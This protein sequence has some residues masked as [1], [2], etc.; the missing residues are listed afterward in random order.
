MGYYMDLETGVFASRLIGQ[1]HSSYTRISTCRFDSQIWVLHRDRFHFESE[2]VDLQK[3]GKTEARQTQYIEDLENFQG[4]YIVNKHLICLQAGRLDATDLSSGVTVDSVPFSQER[5]TMFQP[6]HG[7][8]S[9]LLSEAPDRSNSNSVCEQALFTFDGMK[10]RKIANWRSLEDCVHIWSASTSYLASLHVDGK[11]TEIRDSKSGEVIAE[12]MDEPSL[13]R[14]GMPIDQTIVWETDKGCTD[15][16]SG[17]TLPVPAGSR[18]VA[19]DVDGQQL[20]TLRKKTNAQLGWDC[21]V[22]DE[23]NGKELNRF[24]IPLKHCDS[25]SK[26]EAPAFWIKSDRLVIATR[27]YGISIYDLK[28]GELIREFDPFIWSERWSWIAAFGFGIWCIVWLNGSAKLHPHGWLDMAVCS[29]LVIACCCI[30]NQYRS[31]TQFELCICFGIFGCW[32]LAATTWLFFGKTRWSLRFQP[33][34][35]LLGATFGIVAGL[36]VDIT[37]LRS[38]PVDFAFGE[39]FLMAIYFFSMIL[40]RCSGL[41]F[42]VAEESAH[43]TK[44]KSS[45]LALRDLFTL[46]IVFALLFTIARW[47]PAVQWLKAT[48]SDW[49]SL[50]MFASMIALPSLLAMWTATSCRGWSIRWGVWLVAAIAYEILAANVAW[51]VFRRELVLSSATATLFCFYAYRLRGWRLNPPIDPKRQQCERPSF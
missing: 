44:P 25:D 15:I 22:L 37:W 17:K 8:Q 11:T 10:I 18:L 20:V 41:R 39:M 14:K 21:I 47:M 42:V 16:L 4:A 31:E 34:L 3:N 38:E 1:R 13:I 49:K 2:W 40:L 12:Y 7:T 26:Y 30:R 46:T 50:L 48:P 28:L 24:D 33:L 36:L 32:I 29:G 27:S 19:R 9:I 51:G 45:M 5:R 35:L 6:V 23:V 43:T